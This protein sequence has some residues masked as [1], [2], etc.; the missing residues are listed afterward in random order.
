V[1]PAAPGTAA[2]ARVAVRRSLADRAAVLAVPE[3]PVAGGVGP[4]V[5]HVQVLLDAAGFAPGMLDGRWSE[6]TLFAVRAFRD[7]RGLGVGDTVDAATY[8]ALRAAALDR[9]A[10]TSY[11][12]SDA[13]VRGP[14]RAVP[15]GVRQKASAPCLCYAS[16]LERLS[17]RFH[18]TP[19]LLRTLNPALDF[20]TAPAGTRVVVP[21]TWRLPPKERVARLVVTKREGSVRGMAAAGRTLF[22]LPATVGSTAMPS[23]HG[24][25]RVTSVTRDPHY[26]WDPDVLKD[27][28]RST[29]VLMLPPGP[30]SP[31]GSVW[32]ALSKPRVGIHGTPDPEHVGYT[33]SHGCVRVT[34]WD[35][36]WVARIAR[37]GLAVEFQ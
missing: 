31:V 4:E 23:P 11:P 12:L 13:D 28:S 32:V 14:Y 19:A 35:A 2:T 17:E 26:R 8:A 5:L 3:G 16:L 34:N 24:Q 18:A 15:K 9:P 7:A 10:L 22:F 29:G 25:L 30:N 21:N 33:A 20:A 27:V 37:P 1:F 6:N 36:L